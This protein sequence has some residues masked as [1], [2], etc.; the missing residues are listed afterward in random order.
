MQEGRAS[1]KLQRITGFPFLTSFS[2]GQLKIKKRRKECVDYKNKRVTREWGTRTY[3]SQKENWERESVILSATKSWREER[4]RRGRKYLLIVDFFEGTLEYLEGI[5][6]TMLTLVRTRQP[7]SRE[8]EDMVLVKAWL[9][10]KHEASSWV[11]CVMLF[12]GTREREREIQVMKVTYNWQHF[13]TKKKK[14][15]WQHFYF[16]SFSLKLT[17]LPTDAYWD[18]Q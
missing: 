12:M 4:E 11:Q 7:C 18:E 5:S 8:R 15:N 1:E 13:L 17:S 6:S 9:G 3:Q 2:F 10:L 16:S 14:K